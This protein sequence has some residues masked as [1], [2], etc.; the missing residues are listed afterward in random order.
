M[1]DYFPQRAKEQ[2]VLNLFVLQRRY[3]D[4]GEYSSVNVGNGY[5]IVN[6]FV[7]DGFL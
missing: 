5:E 7:I 4:E 1:V 2:G 6:D 3:S